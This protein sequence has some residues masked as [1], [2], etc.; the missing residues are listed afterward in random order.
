M[1]PVQAHSL[2]GEGRRRRRQQ[3]LHSCALV[4]KGGG[5]RGSSSCTHVWRATQM[6]MPGA[7]PDR[8]VAFARC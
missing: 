1:E 6:G 2:G 4:E 7:L 8:V 3:P 5:E